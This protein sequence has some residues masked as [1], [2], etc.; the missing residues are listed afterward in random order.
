MGSGHGSFRAGG[1]TFPWI[2]GAQALWAGIGVT[3]PL[4]AITICIWG[5]AALV[6]LPSCDNLHLQ[7][8]IAVKELSEKTGPAHL[9]AVFRLCCSKSPA[10]SLRLEVWA[11]EPRL[12]NRLQPLDQRVPLDGAEQRRPSQKD[13]SDGSELL[14]SLESLLGQRMHPPYHG[15]AT[16]SKAA[17]GRRAAKIAADGGAR[18]D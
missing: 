6:S 2:L 17:D 3:I 12:Q 8:Y 11:L 10:V 18:K 13:R 7:I 4:L 5:W 9:P 16:K 15:Y 1:G 14:I